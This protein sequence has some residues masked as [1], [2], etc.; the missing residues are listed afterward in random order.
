MAKLSNKFIA[1]LLTLALTA[2]ANAGL[3]NWMALSMADADSAQGSQHSHEIESHPAHSLH[4]HSEIGEHSFEESHVGHDG[5]DCNEHCFSCVN[6]CS[7][8][9]ILADSMSL[10]DLSKSQH[11]FESGNLSK[12]SDLLYRPPIRS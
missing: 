2:P 4:S 1:L 5:E 10:R 7:T 12:Y 9:G 3:S 6:H 8:M 11:S